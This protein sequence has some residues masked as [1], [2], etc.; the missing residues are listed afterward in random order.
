MA[1]V[2]GEAHAH[3]SGSQRESRS[4]ASRVAAGSPERPIGLSAGLGFV[5]GFVDAFGFL[6]LFGLFTAH[7]TGNLILIGAELVDPDPRVLAKLL[8]V[9]AFMVSV[10]AVR[11]VVLACEIRARPPLRT[12][13][14][15]Q[16]ALLAAFLVAGLAASPIAHSD[17]PGAIIAGLFAI[18]AMAVQNSE[19]R[20]VLGGLAPTTV[21]TGNLAQV[22]IDL[23]DLARAAPAEVQAAARA[24]LA[25]LLPT[26][27]AFVAGVVG[28]AFGYVGGSF[29]GLLL[30]I[31]LLLA[32]AA[33]TRREARLET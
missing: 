4:S 11:L 30:P 22:V 19:M 32:L 3:R 31:T 25:H 13:L 5:A 26:L 18:A 29:W 7:I 6:A 23:V 20:L 8:A 1:D 14:L 10:V 2:T 12:L 21:M 24:R 27:V 15:L 16:A 28:G 17:E 9:P 33:T